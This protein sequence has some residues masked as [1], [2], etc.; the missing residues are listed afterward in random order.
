MRSEAPAGTWGAQEA[1]TDVDLVATLARRCWK[2]HPSIHPPSHP[3]I[4]PL[5]HSL[6]PRT[7]LLLSALR[8]SQGI[9][10]L[11]RQVAALAGNV[12]GTAQAKQ[13]F[14]LLCVSSGTCH[15]KVNSH[16]VSLDPV[17]TEGGRSES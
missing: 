15:R 4:H 13:Q 1:G 5:I 16:G 10:W 17:Q 14:F 8:G 6:I 9:Q 7:Y 3:P 2:L 12:S 11:P